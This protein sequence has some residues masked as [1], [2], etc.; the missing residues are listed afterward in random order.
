MR[1]GKGSR[2]S[3]NIAG[4]T[5]R[6]SQSVFQHSPFWSIAA[7][8][9]GST[10]AVYALGV[11]IAGGSKTWIASLLV[12]AVAFAVAGAA[13]VV[14]FEFRRGLA[15]RF[16]AALALVTNIATFGLALAV[17]ASLRW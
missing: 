9:L 13:Y 6:E 5:M 10:A 8:A 15:S 2:R 11:A 4:D 16:L 3:G 1:V 7:A 12:A 14:V 17:A